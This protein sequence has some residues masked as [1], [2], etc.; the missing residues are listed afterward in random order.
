MLTEEMVRAIETDRRRGIDE[1]V[2]RRRWLP[3]TRWTTGLASRIRA[4]ADV[5]TTVLLPS[6]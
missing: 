3:R 1:A 5:V 2:R 6:R 4:A